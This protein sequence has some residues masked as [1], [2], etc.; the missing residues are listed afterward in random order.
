MATAVLLL[1]LSDVLFEP[2]AKCMCAK[3]SFR[4]CSECLFFFI[5]KSKWCFFIM[6]EHSL[7]SCQILS[8]LF[9]SDIEGIILR[10]AIRGTVPAEYAV[11]VFWFVWLHN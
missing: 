9:N 7:G 1:L 2:S 8:H 11:F 5:F 4:N 10:S 6:F 3:P